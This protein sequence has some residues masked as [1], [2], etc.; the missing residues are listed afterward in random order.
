MIFLILFHCR[1]LSSNN[2]INIDENAFLGLNNL[3][4]LVLQN[5]GLKTVPFEALSKVPSLTTL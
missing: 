2:L 3:Q 1:D 4:R 5:C